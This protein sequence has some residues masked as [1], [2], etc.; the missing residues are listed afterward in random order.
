M[1]FLNKKKREPQDISEVIKAYRDLEKKYNEVEKR[2]IDL[3]KKSIQ[4]VGVIRF[5]PFSDVGGDQSFSVALLDGQD[6]GVIVTGLYSR[7]ES[8]TFAKPVKNGIST[9]NLSDNEEKV[10]AQARKKI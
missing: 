1:S 10:I 3:E 2:L 4:K 9:Y 8:R 5:N 6:D 7:D